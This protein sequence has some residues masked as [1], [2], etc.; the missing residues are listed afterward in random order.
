M[1]LGILAGAAAGQ[2]VYAVDDDVY[3]ESALPRFE[4]PD[5]VSEQALV[6]PSYPRSDALLQIEVNSKDSSF[7]YWIDPA[8]ISVSDDRIVRYTMLMR[9]RTGVEN[10][11]YEGLRCDKRQYRR[12][13]YGSDGVF[14]PVTG[15]DWKFVRKIPRDRYRAFLLDN[16]FC[17]LPRDDYANKLRE[18]LR[19]RNAYQPI[20]SFE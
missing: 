9:S 15:S 19:R 10:V 3:G 18:K 6:L 5:A 4:S 16:Y 11:V 13:A 7:S 20:N 2:M 8:S 17:P 1:F 14:Q 12:Y